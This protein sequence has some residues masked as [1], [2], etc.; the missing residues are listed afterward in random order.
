MEDLIECSERQVNGWWR[1]GTPSCVHRMCALSSVIA[2][3]QLNS[4]YLQ[5]HVRRETVL[6]GGLLDGFWVLFFVVY[7]HETICWLF[8]GL[9]N[10]NEII[11][12]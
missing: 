9:M 3:S 10:V 2:S 1:A 7:V 6:V 4:I 8:C 12:Y 11:E 5:S